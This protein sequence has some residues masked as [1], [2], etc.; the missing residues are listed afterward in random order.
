[1][2]FTELKEHLKNNLDSCYVLY[3]EDQELCFRAETMFK[4]LVSMLP[5]FNLCVLDSK[6]T[7]PQKVV[8]TC[9]TLPV[10]NN[11]KVVILNDLDSK[12]E[13]GENSKTANLLTYSNYLKKPNSKT[14]LVIRTKENSALFNK[15]KNMATLVDCA[16]LPENVLN[17]FIT[18]EAQKMDL[19][20]TNGAIQ[21]LIEISNSYMGTITQTLNKLKSYGNQQITETDIENT[22]E[23]SLEYSV[24][25]L[26]DALSQKNTVKT[27]EILQDMMQNTKDEQ[28]ILPLIASH[29]RRLFMVATST[30]SLEDKARLLGVKEYAV[31]KAQEQSKLFTKKQL[32]EI[33]TTLNESEFKIKSGSA[34]LADTLNYLV[35]LILNK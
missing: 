32:L 5:E 28:M 27:Y 12:E 10:M 19:N 2:K 31:K 34:L 21:K 13:K 16:R 17:K 29:F 8:D 24:F 20:I 3:G 7:T 26:T 30:E 14:V 35:L 33:M 9:N 25:N 11:I 1:M 15:V 4:N 18:T 6:E 22:C 23:K